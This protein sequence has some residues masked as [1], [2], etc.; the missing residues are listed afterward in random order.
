MLTNAQYQCKCV[1]I[2][3][4]ECFIRVIRHMAVAAVNGLKIETFYVTK[5]TFTE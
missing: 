4:S 3:F 1:K 2:V 5:I